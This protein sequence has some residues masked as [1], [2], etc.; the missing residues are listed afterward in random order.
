MVFRLGRPAVQDRS[1]KT[2][3]PELVTRERDGPTFE[4]GVFSQ[5][6]ETGA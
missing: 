5:D 6:H 1:P 3:G 4:E 2:S